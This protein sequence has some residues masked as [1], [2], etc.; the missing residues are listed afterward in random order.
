MIQSFQRDPLL[1]SCGEIMTYDI[2]KNAFKKQNILKA[3][4]EEERY[5]Y[6]E[7]TL[8]PSD[9]EPDETVLMKCDRCGY[10]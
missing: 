3:K 10:F 8:T 4:A 7:F 2:N 1:C 5:D 6:D 9:L